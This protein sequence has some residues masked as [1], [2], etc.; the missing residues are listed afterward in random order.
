MVCFA[1]KV[2]VFVLLIHYLLMTQ[3]IVGDLRLV[4]F[5]YAVIGV[6]SG[7][8]ISPRKRERVALLWFSSCCHVAVDI[9]CL[10]LTVS[11][12]G[13]KCVIT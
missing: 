11:W 1:S 13:L 2:M 5:C 6:L 8:A 7:F 9:P 3:L 4:L 10:F 12:I